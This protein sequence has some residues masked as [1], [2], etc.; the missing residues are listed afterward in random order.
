[1]TNDN[2]GQDVSPADAAGQVD[3][4]SAEAP[5]TPG[6]NDMGDDQGADIDHDATDDD[7]QDSGHRRNREAH[8]RRRSQAAEAERD[9]LRAQLDTLHQDIVNEIAPAG[10][11]DAR[12][13][14]A[15]GHELGSFIGEDGRLDRAAVAEACATTAAE[16]GVTRRSRPLPN[17]QQ[18]ARGVPAAGSALAGVINDALG[19]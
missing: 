4:D 14:V 3:Q 5:E 6:S 10:G 2:G 8:Y 1:V 18:G 12:L 9:Q 15:A 13:L 11:V 7:D 17:P 19:R 16:F